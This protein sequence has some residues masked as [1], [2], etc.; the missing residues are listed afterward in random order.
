MKALA[1]AV[2]IRAAKDRDKPE[3]Q[4]DV[5][6]FLKSDW[7]FDVAELAG[8]EEDEFRPIRTSIERGGFDRSKLRSPYH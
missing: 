7:F 8:F 5:Q 4:T 6:E 2:L 1:A 3:F